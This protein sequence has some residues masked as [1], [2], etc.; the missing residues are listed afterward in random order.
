MDAF[1]A[2]ALAVPRDQAGGTN[3][4]TKN[5]GVA[6]DLASVAGLTSLHLQALAAHGV[7]ILE[8]LA[9]LARDELLEIVGGRVMTQKQAGAV[10]MAA[11]AH[12]F[13]D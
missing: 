2:H 4:W 3:L 12:W 13:Q 7:R 1:S 11:R 10:I 9:D 5:M 6:D 8:D